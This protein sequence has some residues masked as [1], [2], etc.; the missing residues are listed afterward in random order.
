MA[1]DEPTDSC[2]SV[3]RLQQLDRCFTLMDERCKQA[4]F[5]A[6]YQLCIW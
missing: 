1:F 6:P 3:Q 4:M 5:L 2:I